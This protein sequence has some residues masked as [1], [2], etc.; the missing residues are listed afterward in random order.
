MNNA[1]LR[2][3]IIDHGWC[4]DVQKGV[5]HAFERPGMTQEEKEAL[6]DKFDPFLKNLAQAFA[7]KS[8]GDVYV[9]VPEGSLPND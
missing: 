8:K 1:M 2:S 4:I 9:F 5:V 6:Q 3:G 7:E